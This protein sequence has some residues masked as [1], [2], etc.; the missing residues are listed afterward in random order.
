MRIISSFM[1]DLVITKNRCHSI[2]FESSHIQMQFRQLIKSYFNR[3]VQEECKY[4][5]IVNAEGNLIE[6]KDFYFIE[7]NCQ[8][9]S[10]KEEKSTSLIIQDLLKY[11]LENNPLLLEEYIKLNTELERFLSVI[12]FKKNDLIIEFGMSEKLIANIVKS[13]VISIEHDE[14]DYVPNYIIREF[15][16]QS[17]L[18]LN[19]TNK[20][21]F[22]LLSFPEIDIGFEDYS[23]VMQF[24]R[25]LNITTLII[26]SHAY[27]SSVVNKK[28]MFLI[29]E[30]G[31]KYDIIGL[32]KE[33]IEFELVNQEQE[34]DQTKFLAFKDFTK[35]YDLFD[36]KM[37]EFLL[38]N[39]H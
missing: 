6:P 30:N 9:I 21:P 28:E 33:L 31:G 38:S 15:L 4:L 8:S 2:S 36:L 3:K 19:A 26:T 35:D 14:K 10:L 17:L 37:K 13:F 18:K 12:E 7:F 24:F 20:T 25:E 11:Q 16:I 29:K 32:G 39:R 34:S 22:L 27:F 1:D 5:K 23:K